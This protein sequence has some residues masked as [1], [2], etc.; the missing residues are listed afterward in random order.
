MALDSEAAFASRLVY[1]VLTT[2]RCSLQ[3][4]GW[5]T[6]GSFTLFL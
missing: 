1:L 5:A 3:A 6:A 4:M 2:Y